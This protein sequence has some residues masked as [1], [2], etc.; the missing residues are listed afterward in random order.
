MNPSSRPNALVP[1]GLLSLAAMALLLVVAA[2]DTT[3]GVN[4]DPPEVTITAPL[5]DARFEQADTI[6]FAG[7]AVDPE[8]GPLTGSSLTWKSS[9]DGTIGSGETISVAA[10]DLSSGSHLITLAATDSDG[11]TGS[12]SINVLVVQPPS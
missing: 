11:V 7:S 6:T 2:C 5:T 3:A 9:L 10:A 12:A 4:S 1:A 8:D